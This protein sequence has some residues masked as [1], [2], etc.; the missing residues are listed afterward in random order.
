[1]VLISGASAGIGTSQ[2][3][4]MSICRSPIRR[5][6]E[7]GPMTHRETTSRILTSAGIP[8][9]L[10]ELLW[11]DQ[12][13]TLD[14][15]DNH[16]YHAAMNYPGSDS[17]AETQSNPAE[18]VTLTNFLGLAERL[19]GRIADAL[20]RVG[21]TFARYELLR[22]LQDTGEPVSLSALA[23]SHHCARSNITQIIDRLEAEGLVRRVEDPDDRRGVRAELTALGAARAAE[24]ATQIDL[25][26]AQFAANFNGSDRMQL[27]R[28]LGR[29]S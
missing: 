7:G 16:I 18:A 13:E 20:A 17:R 9:R 8:L 2:S 4:P 14:V 12:L 27:G 24:G 10:G 26:R 11:D 21:L 1:M 22:H 3:T 15:I 29:L 28:L 5:F 23:E 25:V 19:Y 6:Q